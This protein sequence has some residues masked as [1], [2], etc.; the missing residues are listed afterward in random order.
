MSSFTTIQS[1]QDSLQMAELFEE[2]QKRG[3]LPGSEIENV[4]T[5]YPSTLS[6]HESLPT[7]HRIQYIQENRSKQLTVRGKHMEPVINKLMDALSAKVLSFHTPRNIFYNPGLQYALYIELEGKTLEETKRNAQFWNTYS[8]TLGKCL[9]EIHS[10]RA[11]Y[12]HK[13]TASNEKTFLDHLKKKLE[14]RSTLDAVWHQLAMQ[15][16]KQARTV[17][18]PEH[19]VL[20][21]GHFEA[22]NILFNSSTRTIGVIDFTE[23]ERFHP[24]LDVATFLMHTSVMLHPF[25][26]K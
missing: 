16:R 10:T 13:R 15:L 19:A 9:A 24:A 2:L 4:Q 3:L 6:A 22:S 26:S 12:I 23:A 21:H 25:L 5:E 20:N 1:L 7:R 14:S 17:A 18:K 8:E 11:P